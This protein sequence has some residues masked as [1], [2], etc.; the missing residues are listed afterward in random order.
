LR[1]RNRALSFPRFLVRS[2]SSFAI[3]SFFG[4]Q[5]GWEEFYEGFAPLETQAIASL[6]HVFFI[7]TIF[8]KRA[9]FLIAPSFLLVD[10]VLFRSCES[11]KFFFFSRLGPA[12]YCLF[13]LFP[14]R[15]LLREE[16]LRLLPFF[17]LYFR[18]RIVADVFPGS[19]CN[20]YF[21]SSSNMRRRQRSSSR[22]KCRLSFF[23]LTIPPPPFSSFRPF[24]F[25]FRCTGG[26]ICVRFFDFS[27]GVLF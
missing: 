2:R 27:C 4:R 13:P 25:S 17:F 1:T 5:L 24:F 3:S 6:R 12:R 14:R 11:P 16:I 9:H 15:T 23:P 18:V 20:P 10:S 22:C 8:L 21:F 19:S 26:Q 7:L